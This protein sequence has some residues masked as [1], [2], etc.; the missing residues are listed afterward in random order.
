MDTD[1]LMAEIDDLLA[2]YETTLN[3]TEYEAL[4]H[5]CLTFVQCCIDLCNVDYCSRA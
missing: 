3:E 1:E 4:L 5:Q 2:M